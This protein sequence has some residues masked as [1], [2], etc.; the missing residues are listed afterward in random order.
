MYAM[1]SAANSECAYLMVAEMPKHVVE[2]SMELIPSSEAASREA[3]QEFRNML[4]N[5]K[6]YYCVHKSLPLVPVLSQMNTVHTTP[7][8]FSKI[9]F[10]I[11]LPLTSRS[12]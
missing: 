3:T 1:S 9:H 2:N 8:H 6:V 7:S 12:S 10:N 4:W 11:T 5:P